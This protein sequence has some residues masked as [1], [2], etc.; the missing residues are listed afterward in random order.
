MSDVEE[1][2]KDLIKTVNLA[3]EFQI[4]MS[5]SFGG[6]F[7]WCIEQVIDSYLSLFDRFSPYQIGD[8]VKLIKSCDV[9]EDSG[10][11]NSRHYLIKGSK[12]TVKGR[13]YRDGKFT[14]EIMFDDETWIDREGCKKSVS[15]KHSFGFSET[16]LVGI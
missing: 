3:K 15:Q 1:Y 5:K 2:A 6:S 7:G 16:M 10:W 8:R 14:F 9:N 4:E 13:G 12:A 11:Y